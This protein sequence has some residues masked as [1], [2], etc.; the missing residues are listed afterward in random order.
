MG[1]NPT[2]SA[3]FIEFNKYQRYS[4]AR[5]RALRATTTVLKASLLLGPKD[6]RACATVEG[7]GATKLQSLQK[8]TQIYYKVPLVFMPIK[9]MNIITMTTP[10]NARDWRI[11]NVSISIFINPKI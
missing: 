5:V 10:N 1:S 2:P 6:G 11:E 7:H 8:R 4:V 3:I 9:I